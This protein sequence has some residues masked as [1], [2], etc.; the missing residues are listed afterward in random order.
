MVSWPSQQLDI[1]IAVCLLSPWQGGR[2][3]QKTKIRTDW[4]KDRLIR[5]YSC[6]CKESKINNLLFPIG[7]QMSLVSMASLWTIVTWE[8]KCHKHEFPLF[9]LL[10][11]KILLLSKISFGIKF[12]SVVLV[13]PPYYL[14]YSLSKG[15]KSTKKIRKPQCSAST[16]HKLLRHWCVINTVLVINPI[17]MGCYEES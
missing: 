9:L 4:D 3:N 12:G 7:R 16:A 2:G 5:K 10:F 8:N 17:H 1:H 15:K 6:V 11:P 14:L 13:I